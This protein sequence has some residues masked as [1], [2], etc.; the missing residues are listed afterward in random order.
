[1]AKFELCEGEEKSESS[2]PSL[3]SLP[4]QIFTPLTE[5]TSAVVLRAIE[6]VEMLVGDDGHNN[7][8]LFC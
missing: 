1:M 3:G 6:S 8:R 4:S 2:H 7:S 5:T